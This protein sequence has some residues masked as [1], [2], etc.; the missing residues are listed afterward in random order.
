MISDREMGIVWL[1]CQLRFSEE[2]TSVEGMVLSSVKIRIVANLEGTMGSDI[3]QW[4]D[5]LIR[6][7]TEF[8]QEV[9]FC[10]FLKNYLEILANLLMERLTQCC[11]VVQSRLVEDGKMGLNGW[12]V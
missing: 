12:Q 9:Q 10:V 7:S 3:L 6:K 2:S 4:K 1:Q 5:A 11:K 8:L